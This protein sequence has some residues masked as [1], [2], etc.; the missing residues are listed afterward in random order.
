MHKPRLRVQ[1]TPRYHVNFFVWTARSTSRTPLR[2]YKLENILRSENSHGIQ[3]IKAGL[4]ASNY[5]ESVWYA[6]KW[7]AVSTC[8]K[9]LTLS[10]RSQDQTLLATFLF[11]TGAT[12]R[13]VRFPLGVRAS[14]GYFEKIITFSLQLRIR[15]VNS[16]FEVY[17][18]NFQNPPNDLS[19][20]EHI[21]LLKCS[22]AL[23]DHIPSLTLRGFGRCLP[24]L[25][26]GRYF[27]SLGLPPHIILHAWG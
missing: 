4:Q 16:R 27:K 11:L 21:H 23:Y 7:I 9:Y 3:V 8:S 20:C 25:H 18:P 6:D 14:Y 13:H 12:P 5:K 2:G 22:N 17:K 1:Y 15:H 10:Q 19:N 26:K 24:F